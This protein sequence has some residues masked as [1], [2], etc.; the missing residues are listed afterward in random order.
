MAIFDFFSKKKHHQ[1]SAVDYK[2]VINQ[3]E[4]LGYFKYADPCDIPA[5][6]NEITASLK[7]H[8]LST[9][10]NDQKPWNG[11]DLR[12]YYLDGEDLFEEDGFTDKLAEMESVFAK[13]NLKMAIT[14]HIED[15]DKETG[16]NH[17]ITINDTPYIIFRNFN[18]YGW[19]EAAQ[20]FAEIIN[21]QLQQ[22]QKDERLYLINGGN[23]GRCVFLTTEQYD[24]LKPYLLDPNERPYP[25]DEWC[26]R[27]EVDRMSY[28]R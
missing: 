2:E 9:I 7:D 14:D 11:K 5:L 25:V 22:Q 8:W 12:H 24:I 10:Y 13:M 17:S 16:L 28:L 19:G 1:S 18:E 27:Y 26:K 21:D 4:V 20:R 23:D 15:W 3:L 6:K